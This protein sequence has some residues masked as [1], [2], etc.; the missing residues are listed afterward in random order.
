MNKEDEYRA[1]QKGR[2]YDLEERLVEFAVSIIGVAERLPKSPAG[3]H[4]AGQLIRSGTSPAANYGEAQSA[5]SRKDFVHKMKLALKELR[6]SR[7]WLHVILRKPLAKDTD[8]VKR[9][10]TECEELIR[11]F[12]KSIATAESNMK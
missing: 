11:I 3:N 7:V 4:I 2:T 10:L 8:E 1:R 5:E 6:E 12:A 9:V